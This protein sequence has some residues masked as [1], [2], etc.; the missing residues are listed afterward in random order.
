MTDS[1]P[2]VI[3]AIQEGSDAPEVYFDEVKV[4]CRYAKAG[5]FDYKTDKGYGKRIFERSGCLELD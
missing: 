2:D 5:E 4:N 1:M 3:Y